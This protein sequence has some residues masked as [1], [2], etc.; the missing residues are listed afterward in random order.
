MNF[1]NLHCLLSIR[2][3]P[4]LY[5]HIMLPR[6][7][8]HPIYIYICILYRSPPPLLQFGEPVGLQLAD[9]SQPTF[10]GIPAR[11]FVGSDWIT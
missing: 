9:L 8:E 4:D 3:I 1:M 5:T 11:T 7:S 2:G 6:H 10:A